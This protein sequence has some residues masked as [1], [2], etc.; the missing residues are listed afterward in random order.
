MLLYIEAVVSYKKSVKDKL[1]EKKTPKEKTTRH[2][3]EILL[4]SNLKVSP[5]FFIVQFFFAEKKNSRN[6]V[7]SLFYALGNFYI[8]KYFNWTS[9]VYDILIG[10]A[11]LP[12]E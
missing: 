8:W 2:I 3:Y 5:R 11:K 6:R 10:R 7:I 9:S 12:V 4:K 1:F